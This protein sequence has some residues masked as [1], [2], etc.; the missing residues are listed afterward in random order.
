MTTRALVDGGYLSGL[1]LYKEVRKH[2]LDAIGNG[3]WRA[4]DVLP[5]EKLLCARFGVSIGTLRKAVDDLTL[6]GVLIRQQGRG[7]FVARHSQGRYLFSFFHLVPRHG[8]KEYPK[9]EF[10]S[11]TKCQADNFAAEQLKI[12]PGDGLIHIVNRLELAGQISSIDDIYLPAG[13]FGNLS[14]EMIKQRNTTLYQLYEDMFGVR[15][16]STKERLRVAS[17]SQRQAKMLGIDTGWPLLHITRVAYSFNNQVVELRISHANT[18]NCEYIPG[19]SN[20]NSL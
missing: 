6:S 18:E 9:I 11:F 17:S 1:P 8:L 13:L 19:N 2:I 12:Q 20:S 10:L 4:G 16:I 3:E 14:R 5:T 7:T 15:V